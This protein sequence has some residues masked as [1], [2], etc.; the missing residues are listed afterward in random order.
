MSI[1]FKTARPLPMGVQP[2]L[3][4][5]QAIPVNVIGWL[6]KQAPTNE[7]ALSLFNQ[8]KRKGSL[9]DKQIAAVE[10]NLQRELDFANR[11][12]V[13]PVIDI[14]KIEA[15]FAHAKVRGIKKPMM[16]VA[17]YK[18]KGADPFGN[19]PGAIWVT[20]AKRDD[21]GEYVYYGKI[22]NSKFLPSRQ[23]TAEDERL[24]LEAVQNPEEAA[25][26][27]GQRTGNCSICGRLLTK[28]ESIDRMIG[29]ICYEA[30]FGA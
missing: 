1:E 7:F 22:V 9:S 14:S 12:Q 5:V 27:Y 20:S 25:R 21:T 15:T 16:R 29:P 24:I 23:C 8:Y 19:N 26:A 6:E 30:Y 10:R 4:T 17:L 3:P 2:N 28:G 13:A 18:L 11:R